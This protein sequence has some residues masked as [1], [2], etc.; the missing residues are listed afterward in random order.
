MYQFSLQA[1]SFQLVG[2]EPLE[3]G[4]YT[5]V[6]GDPQMIWQNADEITLRTLRTPIQFEG[7]PREMCL[8]YTTE[9][10]EAFGVNKRVFAAQQNDGSYL[11]TLPAK[12]VTALRLDPCSPVDRKT[13]QMEFGEFTVNE[14][15]PFYRYFAP[16]WAGLFRML[17][18]PGLCAAI[19]RVAQDSLLWYKTKRKK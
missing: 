8:Y 2:M 16:G 1:E 4:R 5:T 14:P 12:R 9:P 18:L 7:S 19:L 15:V 3:D 17:M 10:G 6:D 13:V 11:Y